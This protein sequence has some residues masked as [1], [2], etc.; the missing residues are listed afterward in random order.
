MFSFLCTHASCDNKF[1]IISY[2]SSVSLMVIV[3]R[4]FFDFWVS[5]N[6]FG[7]WIHKKEF[8]FNSLALRL[9]TIGLLLISSFGLLGE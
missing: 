6:G 9:A 1:Q 7:F 8:G 3:K 5:N 4:Y 2:Q